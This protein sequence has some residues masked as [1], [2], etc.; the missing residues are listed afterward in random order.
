MKKIDQSSIIICSIV[1]NAEKRLRRNIPV[2]QEFCKYF[3]NYRVIVYEN[4]ST[5][6]T[7]KILAEWVDRDSEHIVALMNILGAGKTIPSQNNVTVNPFF[8]RNRI[9]KMACLRN[10]YM[11]YIDDNK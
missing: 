9:E 3:A 11:K 6:N 4:D 8:S 5:D 1:R 2:V 10:Q 7:K